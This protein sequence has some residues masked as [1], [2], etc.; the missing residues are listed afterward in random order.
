MLAAV[1]DDLDRAV[2]VV[3]LDGR[4]ILANGLAQT[5]LGGGM[6]LLG[7]SLYTFLDR[8]VLASSF[9]RL[10]QDGAASERVALVAQGRRHLDARVTALRRP[11]GAS[12]GFV[13]FLH[14]GEAVGAEA[15]IP[16]PEWTQFVGAGT[17]TGGARKPETLHRQEL[18]DFSLLDSAA[19]GLGPNWRDQPLDEATFVV[20]DTE[21]TGLDPDRGD[22]V[23][24]L[25]GVK[26][27]AG[28]L[29]RSRV[30]DALVHPGRRI[31]AGSTALHGIDDDRV[32][33]MPALDVVLPAFLRF[34]EGA[35]LA[36]HETWFDLRFIQPEAKRLGLQSIG[37]GAPVLDT[38]LLSRLVHGALADHDLDAVAERLGVTI[39]GRHSALGDAFATAEILV[40]FLVLLRDRGITTLGALL[41]S[42]R[43]LRGSGG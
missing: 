19:S 27:Q 25:A 8:G 3:N 21:T 11:N 41:D 9:G 38:R 16:P 32:A 14:E 2:V 12:A 6:G 29:R 15:V 26:V 24:S 34:A 1:L 18:Y 13:L 31:P 20:F 22:R 37:S 5:W 33:G 4:V 36:G 35:V 40:R 43:S 30:F 39:R 10:R 7:R 42:V 28:V 23:V 17:T